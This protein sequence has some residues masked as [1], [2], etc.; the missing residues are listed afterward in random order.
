[1]TDPEKKLPR[2]LIVDD[3]ERIIHSLQRLLRREIEITGA[4]TSG[5]AIELL[6]KESFDAI[7]AEAS[8]PHDS[9]PGF[10]DWLAEA[11]PDLLARLIVVSGGR[12][13]NF[14]N[15]FAWQR[16]CLFMIKPVS[17]EAL[18]AAVS[19]IADRCHPNAAHP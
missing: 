15:Q 18:T 8:V 7:M 11:R 13:L 14:A 16:R 6:S 2:L 1:M 19:R 3:E 9:M 5:Q 12:R 10:V 17:S 4:T